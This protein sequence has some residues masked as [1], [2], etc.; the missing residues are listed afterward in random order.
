MYKTR[1]I[2]IA[3]QLKKQGYSWLA[4]VPGPNLY[5]FTGLTLKQS[6]RI[7]LALVSDAGDF[8]F[9]LPQVEKDKADE[10]GALEVISYT[11][12][13]GIQSIFSNRFFKE[14][15][16]EEIAV[17]DNRMR[18]IEASVLKKIGFSKLI[19]FSKELYDARAIKSEVEANKIQNAVHIL[20]SSLEKVLKSMQVGMTELDVAALLEFEMKK[21]GSSGTPFE[22]IVASGYRAAMPHGRASDKKLAHG[23]LIIVDFGAYYNGYVGDMSRTIAIGEVSKKQ[24]EVFEIVKIAQA[25]ALEQ[26]KPGQTAHQVDA[27]A[28]DYIESQGYGAYFLHRTGHGMGIEAHE[29]PYI[30][31]GNDEFLKPGMVFT[32]EP[33]IYVKDVCGVRI[34]DNVFV[35]KNGYKNFMSFTKELIILEG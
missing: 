12:R 22:T 5:Y 17:E 1:R 29:E 6:E 18:L 28:R 7:S 8:V 35:T 11:D 10:K 32:V 15:K 16:K 2:K 3:N 30:R 13:D 26:I 33:G 25:L 19:P 24:K 21:A 4:L 20:E 27:M 34:E 23:E 31:Q 14:I 9:I